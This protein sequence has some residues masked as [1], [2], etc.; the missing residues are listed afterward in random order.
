MSNSQN[1]NA[2]FK[3]IYH[4]FPWTEVIIFSLG[5]IFYLSWFVVGA[6]KKESYLYSLGLITGTCY[7][8]L[9]TWYFVKSPF[10]MVDE[11]GL[12]I[13]P[14]PFRTVR[15]IKWM[16]IKSLSMYNRGYHRLGKQVLVNL[17]DCLGIEYCKGDKTIVQFTE[18]KPKQ[19]KY[20]I[21]DIANYAQSAHKNSTLEGF[22]MSIKDNCLRQPC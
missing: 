14:S 4:C 20:L 12:T 18:I 7:F 21:I 16:D 2:S 3:R 1:E 11:E 22:L 10:Y 5:F 19:F 15:K 9:L 13:R 6:V 8:I 17:G